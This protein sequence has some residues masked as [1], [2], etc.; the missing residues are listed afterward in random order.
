MSRDKISNKEKTKQLKEE[1]SEHFNN[2]SLLRCKTMGEIVKQMLRYT[3]KPHLSRIQKNLG[4]I[5][6]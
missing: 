6:D 4:K 3:L 1:L 2:P 5:T